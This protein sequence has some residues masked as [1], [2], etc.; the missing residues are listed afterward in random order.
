MIYV[1]RLGMLKIVDDMDRDAAG[2]D[3]MIEL[4]DDKRAVN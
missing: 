2:W 1:N 3:G 4:L